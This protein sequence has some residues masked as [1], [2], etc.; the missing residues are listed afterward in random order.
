M[1]RF[2]EVVLQDASSRNAPDDE[3]QS[4]YIPSVNGR[5]RRLKVTREESVVQLP[6]P[7]KHAFRRR[8]TYR[9]KITW[10]EN[11]GGSEEE[12]PAPLALEIPGDQTTQVVASQS[13]TIPGPRSLSCSL[14]LAPSGTPLLLVFGTSRWEPRRGSDTLVCVRVCCQDQE[15]F[16]E[17]EPT[18]TPR[19]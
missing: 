5:R 15:V 9:D 11:E 10:N 4:S 18:V 17:S 12:G 8:G 7:V 19:K 16:P 14:H 3:K 1:R 2:V 6:T 13:I